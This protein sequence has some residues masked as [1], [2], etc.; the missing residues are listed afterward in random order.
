M[1][2]NGLPVLQQMWSKHAIPFYAS[3][4]VLYTDKWLKFQDEIFLPNI[5]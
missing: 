2:S 4:I 5:Q 1:S 3:Y